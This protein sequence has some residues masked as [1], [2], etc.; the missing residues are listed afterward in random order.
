MGIGEFL[1]SRAHK[2]FIYA[3][4]RRALWEF[5]HFRGTEVDLVS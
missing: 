2:E 1:S 3:E 4:K 5:K